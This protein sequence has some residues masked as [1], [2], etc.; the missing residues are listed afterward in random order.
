MTGQLRQAAVN[1]SRPSMADAIPV[2]PALAVSVANSEMVPAVSAR[3]IWLLTNC[4]NQTAPSAPRAMP[5]G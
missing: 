5:S 1:Q 3:P 2:G 4:V